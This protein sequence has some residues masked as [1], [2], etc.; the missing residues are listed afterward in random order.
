LIP[1]LLQRGA[2]WRAQS[3]IG[4]R[5]FFFFGANGDGALPALIAAQRLRAASPIAFLP[6]ALNVRFGVGATFFGAGA[7][8]FFEPGG[9][10]RLFESHK[11]LL[12][13]T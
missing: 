10:P 2:N 6:A 5:A 8:A 9:L 1:I 12:R 4:Y 3:V 11:V 13:S 7:L